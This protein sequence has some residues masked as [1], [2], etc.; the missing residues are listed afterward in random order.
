MEDAGVRIQGTGM[1]F[2]SSAATNRLSQEIA[3]S[4]VDAGIV[5]IIGARGESNK[6]PLATRW[7]RS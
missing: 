6:P 5:A 2:A 3:I 1:T 4:P 7:G